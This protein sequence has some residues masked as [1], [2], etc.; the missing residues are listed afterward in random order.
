MNFDLNSVCQLSPLLNV[1]CH[2]VC[3]LSPLLNVAFHSRQSPL[4][5]DVTAAP[6]LDVV[7]LLASQLPY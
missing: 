6:A 1:A 4:P 3:Q 2:S 5:I 7:E